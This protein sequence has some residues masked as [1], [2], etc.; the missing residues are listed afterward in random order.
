MKIKLLSNRFPSA[1]TILPTYQCTAACKNCCFGCT[2]NIKG[3]I[4]QDR[5]LSYIGE[6]KKIPSLR[7]VVFS[8]G[9]CFL[10]G[11]DLDEAIGLASGKDVITRCV[12]NGYW[13][14]S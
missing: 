13:A 12:T 7:L 2:P 1:L 8:G 3:R 5:L 6:A 14:D 9:E 11:E 4:P 10:L